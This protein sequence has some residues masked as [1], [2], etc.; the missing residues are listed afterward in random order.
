MLPKTSLLVLCI[1]A[2]CATSWRHVDI[3]KKLDHPFH[4]I[5]PHAVV[6]SH[7]MH[8]HKAASLTSPLTG[9]I[10]AGTPIR[11]RAQ[12]LPS[13]GFIPS[14]KGYVLFDAYVSG[15]PTQ[16]ILAQKHATSKMI[17]QKIPLQADL[18]YTTGAD[19]QLTVTHKKN[20]I[21]FARSRKALGAA[22]LTE[23]PVRISLYDI[24]LH[25]NH[26]APS[27]WAV[28]LEDSLRLCVPYFDKK[29]HLHIWSEGFGCITPKKS[30]SF[31]MHQNKDG[32]VDIWCTHPQHTLKSSRV[33]TITIPKITRIYFRPGRAPYHTSIAP[34]GKYCLWPE[35]AKKFF[36]W[37]QKYV[38]ALV[39]NLPEIKKWACKKIIAESLKMQ[40][41]I[42]D[43]LEGIGY[44]QPLSYDGLMRHKKPA[45]IKSSLA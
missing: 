10:P 9:K 36:S 22:P 33:K 45:S 34:P 17:F 29:G 44:K 8:G 41:R 40:K 20:D 38:A 35:E 5:P 39:Y 15:T 6:F 14:P 25:K 13:H 37:D 7:G 31:I 12:F 23:G 26:G 2:F 18:L 32:S 16:T 42:A 28:I 11:F 43:N 27:G 4:F 3:H 24:V 30:T 19:W 1:S 21:I